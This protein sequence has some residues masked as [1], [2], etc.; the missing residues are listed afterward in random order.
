MDRK[1]LETA[2]EKNIHGLVDEVKESTVD[3][4]VLTVRKKYPEIDR[5][6]LSIVL[7]IVR[8]GIDN[9]FMT[10]IDRYMKRLDKDLTEL[11]EA[12]VP[13]EIGRPT[14]PKIKTAPVTKKG[15]PSAKA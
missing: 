13:L 4:T 11:T 5:D 3:F 2:I 15:R 6:Q 7:D 8:T 10:T 12:S 9:G 1:R 14:T